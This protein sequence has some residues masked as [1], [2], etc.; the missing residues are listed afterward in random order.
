MM[1]MLVS[2]AITNYEQWLNPIQMHILLPFWRAEVQTIHWT[3]ASVNILTPSEILYRR[4]HFFVFSSLLETYLVPWLGDFLIS[5]QS[6]ASIVGNLPIS[7]LKS[8][9]LPSYK[10]AY[11]ITSRVR[12]YSSIISPYQDH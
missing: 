10:D 4:I 9:L 11:M 7:I 2:Y 12:R 1:A 3:K 5:L 6:L 8:P